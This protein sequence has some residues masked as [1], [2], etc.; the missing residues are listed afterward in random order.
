MARNQ[1]SGNFGEGFS[2]PI[3]AKP[4][5]CC[6]ETFIV[7][8]TFDIEQE[9]NNCWKYIKTKFFRALVGVRK[10]DQGASKAVYH[11][12]PLQI[13]IENSD[14]YWSKSISEID[15][16]LYKNIIYLKKK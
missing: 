8:G 15:C 11:Y 9:M 10:Q 16:Q 7:I 2:T 14:I 12:V 6:T 3:F 1:G 13:F 5:E 4:N